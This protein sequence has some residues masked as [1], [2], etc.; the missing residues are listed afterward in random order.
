MDKKT[1]A[2]IVAFFSFLIWGAL[3]IY[4]HQL[5]SVNPL[6]VV[7]HRAIWS[8]VFTAILILVT[9]KAGEVIHILKNPRN[10]LPLILSSI[11][12]AGNWGLFIWAV[13]NDKIIESSM[14]NYITPLLNVA[15]SAVIFKVVL[16]KYQK[17]S[18]LLAFAGVVYMIIV[19]GKVPYIAIFF[20][21]TFCTYGIIKKLV[22]ASALT[23][24]FVETLII[25]VPSVIY[26]LYLIS[27]GESAVLKGDALISFLLICGG[28]VTTLPLLGFSYSAKILHLSTLGILQYITPTIA[29]LLGVFVYHEYF[30]ANM[31]ITFILIWTGLIIYSTDGIFQL[32]KMKK[33]RIDN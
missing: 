26:V 28:I 13:A 27:N 30:S 16:N 7:A 29:F 11:L 3:V 4:W 17:L 1:F 24:L 22:P 10:I 8:L 25:S 19:Y 12:I 23:G 2:F 32:K 31:L 15:A 20:A 6:E 18:V 14:G 5:S 33:G 9:K 21:V